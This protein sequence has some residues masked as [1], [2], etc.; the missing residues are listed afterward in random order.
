LEQHYISA[1]L[2]SPKTIEHKWV[3]HANNNWE[4]A[5]ENVMDELKDVQ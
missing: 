3:G 4:L 2:D 5:A 1:G